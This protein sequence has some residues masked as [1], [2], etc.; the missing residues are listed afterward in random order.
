MNKYDYHSA[1]REDVKNYIIENDIKVTTSNRDEL[2]DRLQDDL[3][4]NDSVTGNGSGSY[5]FNT[6]IAEENLCHNLDLLAECCEEFGDDMGEVINRGVETADV[7]IRCYLLAGA[8]SDILD[9]L[10]EEDEE[11]EEEDEDEE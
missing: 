6:W 10:E 5:T 1:V 11:E 7:C 9:E 3:W 2:A 8:I 4:C